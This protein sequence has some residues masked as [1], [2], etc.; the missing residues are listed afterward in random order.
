MKGVD[1]IQHTAS[2]FHLNGSHPDDLIIPALEGTRS[3][4]RSTLKHGTEVKRV[5]LTSSCAA[6][7]EVVTEP[8]TFTED[9]WNTQSTQ[10]V[11]AKGKD[12]SPTHAYRASKTLAEREAWK[13]VED[14]KAEIKWDLVAINPPYIFGPALQEVA[15]AAALNMSMASWHRYV[16]QGTVD[17]ETL[18]TQGYVLRFLRL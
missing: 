6:I 17:N 10:E 1:A 8:R 11:E 14:H 3:I 4:L 12:T 16:L 5:V 2:P 15:S 9:N 7:E 13:F 18:A